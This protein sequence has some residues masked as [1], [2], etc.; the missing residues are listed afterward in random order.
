M[1]EEASGLDPCTEFV[2]GEKEVVATVN[3]ALARRPGGCRDGAAEPGA[4]E[5]AVAD[6]GLA[7]SGGA[8][9]DDEAGR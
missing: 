4:L 5:Q 7:D 3:L 8:G 2:F 9:D 6:C 1:L